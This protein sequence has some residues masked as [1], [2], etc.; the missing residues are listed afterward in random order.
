MGKYKA[1]ELYLSLFPLTR[2]LCP[3]S[4][5]LA[6]IPFPSLPKSKA[7]PGYNVADRGSRGVLKL[8][9]RSGQSLAAKHFWCIY[10]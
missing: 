1:T 7:F 5:P 4:L 3:F 10:S 6:S 8:L 9:K 2:F